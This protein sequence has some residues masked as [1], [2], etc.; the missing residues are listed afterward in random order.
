MQEKTFTPSNKKLKLEEYKKLRAI[1]DEKDQSGFK[2]VNEMGIDYEVTEAG[3]FLPSETVFL[4]K[5]FEDLIS[6]NFINP[7]ELF[8]D[9]GSGDARVNHVASIN[10]IE[11]SIGIEYSAKVLE[12]SHLQTQKFEEEG[13]IKK[14]SVKLICG[15]FTELDTYKKAGINPK[16]IK[17]FFNYVN[18]WKKLLEFINKNS[19]TGTK[20]ILM[21]EQF[22]V[23]NTIIKE[24]SKYKSIE[25][26]EVKKYV[27]WKDKDESEIMTPEVLEKLKRLDKTIENQHTVLDISPSGQVSIIETG[28]RVITVYLSEKVSG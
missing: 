20:L 4:D 27:Y 15:D 22:N 9:A 7:R 2:S 25:L 16:D 3:L 28:Y 6:Q 13:I 18:G 10:G 17:T 14:D 5:L 11:N 19:T 12:K 24:I 8:L 26:K 1:F 21:D 23:S